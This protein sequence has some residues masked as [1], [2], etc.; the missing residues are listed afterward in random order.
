MKTRY[1]FFS[2]LVFAT[3]NLLF[4]VSL[5]IFEMRK[6]EI[7]FFYLGILITLGLYFYASVCNI[8]LTESFVHITSIFKNIEIPINDVNITSVDT[9]KQGEFCI[10]LNSKRIR[11]KYKRENYDRVYQLLNSSPDLQHKMEEQRKKCF[12]SL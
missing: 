2:I 6:G 8:E 7:R 12:S 1:N 4:L 9:F 10:T 11:L 5:L 3:V